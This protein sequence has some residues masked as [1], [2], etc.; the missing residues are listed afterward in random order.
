MNNKTKTVVGL[1]LLTALVIVLQG[2]A[3][4]IRFGVFNITLV[5]VPIV[6]GAA[7]Y[8]YWAGAWLGFVFGVVVLMTDA[9]AF[10]AVS[11]PGTIITCILKGACA[12]LVAG[13]VYKCLEKKNVTLA[14]FVAAVLAPVVNTGLFLV[15][16]R[17]F[18]YD[19]IKAWA[20]GA[21][22]PSAGAFMIGGLVGIN[23]LVEL[24]INLVL[25]LTIVRIIQIGKKMAAGN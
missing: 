6:V 10:L 22:F 13:Y 9:G 18:F 16:C 7:L 24:A 15:G 19:T 5:L 14:V 4:G 25:S 12:G 1:G 2:L 3:V 11:V 20:E 8:G 21:G 17:L 23:F